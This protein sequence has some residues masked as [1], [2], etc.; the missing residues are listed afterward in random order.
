[1]YRTSGSARAIIIIEK[2]AVT[3]KARLIIRENNFHALLLTVVD[4]DILAK[5]G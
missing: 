2:P 5:Q 4:Q 3:R 1:M